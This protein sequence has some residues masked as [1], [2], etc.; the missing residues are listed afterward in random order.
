MAAIFLFDAG[1]VGGLRGAG[2]LRR[3]RRAAPGRSRETDVDSA[4]M[5]SS[6]A[7]L[8]VSGSRLPHDGT[9]SKQ[10]GTAPK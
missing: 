10:L 8:S 1:G 6:V 4:R 3:R 2:D 5:D 9:A 7:S